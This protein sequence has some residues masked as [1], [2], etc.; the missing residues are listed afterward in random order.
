[1]ARRLVK[2]TVIGA[3]ASVGMTLLAVGVERTDYGSAKQILLIAGGFVL[4]G[5]AAVK[6]GRFIAEML[7][8]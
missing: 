2:V 4:L 5:V 1:M 6:F 3:C 8:F 7:Y